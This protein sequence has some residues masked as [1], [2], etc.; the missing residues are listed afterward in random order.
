ML[1]KH[2]RYVLRTF[3][4]TFL[5]AM[6][7]MTVVTVVFDLAE[8]VSRITKYWDTMKAYG[9]NPLVVVARFYGSLVPFFWLQMLPF[10]VPI[11]TVLSLSR[12]ARNREIIPLVTG[13]VSMKRIVMPIVGSAL[14]VVIL[15]Y[16][17]RET[18]V[19]SLSREHMRMGRL[20]SKSEPDRITDVPHFHDASGGR[21]SMAAFMPITSRLEAVFVTYRHPQGAIRE[22][23]W[24]PELTWNA[25][26]EQW[27]ASRGGRRIP[28]GGDGDTPGVR[29]IEIEEGEV[30]PIEAPLSLLE[31]TLTKA[32][33]MGFSFSETREL[34]EANPGNPRFVVMY[35][36]LFTGPLAAIILLLL[37]LPFAVRV[38]PGSAIPGVLAALG[39]SAVYFAATYLVRNVGGSG[40]FNPYVV[41]WLPTVFFFSLGL[42]LFL[43]QRE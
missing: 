37:A 40:L 24:F 31:L 15:M 30:A 19:P 8:R 32:K 16:A 4:S 7:A 3:W 26:A 18:V 25:G 34:L 12:L 22:I 20:L 10:C 39:M 9:E 36:S 33:G 41:A 13:G 21:L 42:A 27:I 6:L 29:R 2:D 11:A 17:A 43:G 28:I 5:V 14:L 23:F 1:R 35:L 38:M